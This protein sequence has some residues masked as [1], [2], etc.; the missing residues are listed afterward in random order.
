M[1]SKGLVK[2]PAPSYY[3]LY[4]GT[5]Q[6]VETVDMR[7]SDAFEKP[8]EGYEWTAHVVNINAGHNAEVNFMY[9]FGVDFEKIHREA[10][11]EE[12][13]NEGRDE[14]RAEVARNMLADGLP[15][16]KIM[17]YTGLPLEEVEKLAASTDPVL[18]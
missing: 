3:V 17:Q 2:I 8:A 1:H 10:M 9:L 15:M 12:A 14:N 13:R 6:N 11:I 7:L 18:A 4:N 16:G 5:D